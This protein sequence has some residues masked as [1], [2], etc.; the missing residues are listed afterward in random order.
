M[1]PMN[2]LYENRVKEQYK[3]SP[4]AGTGEIDNVV[5]YPANPTDQGRLMT[6][7]MN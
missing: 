2:R 1:K 5:V 3:Q 6:A 7:A 4:R